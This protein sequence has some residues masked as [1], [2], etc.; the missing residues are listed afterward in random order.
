M[1]QR[2]ADMAR[3]ER[4]ISM[5]SRT[6]RRLAAAAGVAALTVGLVGAGAG[7]AGAAA[8]STMWQDGSSKFTR[9]VSDTTPNE[10]DVVTVSTKFERT[11]IPGEYIYTVKDVHPTCLTY[12]D[13][14]AKVNGS[15]RALES[16]GADFARVK[17]TV[18]EW[19]VG[20]LIGGKPHTFEFSYRVGADCARGVALPTTMHYTSSLGSGTYSDKGPA[21]TVG[22][23]VSST[24]LAAVPA[25]QVG[26]PVT[27]SATVTGGKQDDPVDF[28]DGSTKIGTGRL[29]ASGAATSSWTPTTAGT[30]SVQ[31]R[32]AATAFAN[33]SDS[34]VQSV[35]VAEA[36]VVTS[37]TLQ[38]PQS[39]LT[40]TPVTLSATVDPS[41]ASGTVQFRDGNTNLGAP[42]AVSNGV[43]MFPHTFT[44]AG[45]HSISAVFTGPGFVSSTAPAQTVTVS[46][47]DLATVTTVDASV[48]AQTGAPVMLSASVTPAPNGGTVQ[49]KDGVAAIGGAVEVVNGTAT[50]EH[51]F[52]SVGSHSIT[53]TYSGAAGFEPSTSSVRSV[54]VT[55]PVVT[56]RSTVTLL[57]VPGEAKTGATTDL[58]VTV[59]DFSGAAVDGGTVQF[60]D[61]G[62]DIGDPVAVSS[63]VARLPHTFTVAGTH[64]V[65]AVFSGVPALD[66]SVAATRNV[67]VTVAAP[68]DVE[69]ATALTVPALATSGTEVTLWVSV[70]SSG[71][72]R[73][74][75]QFFD[76][77]T[78][79][80]EAVELVDGAATLQHSFVTPGAHPITAVYSGAE[81]L[82]GS[83]SEA[84]TVQVASVDSTPGGG[85]GTGS[86][87]GLPFGS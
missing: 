73:G 9:T 44:T 36:D 22:K 20:A 80:G 4:T 3:E 71:P 43:A 47:P 5:T 21:L 76:G 30:R 60:R 35:Q 59:R 58:W 85:T 86:L 51:T 42:V 62:Q 10:G 25:A 68:T 26:K 7:L 57:S 49:F 82:S 81:G 19:P 8:D 65:S 63:G 64:S 38:A 31:A 50:L 17:G 18:T 33:G 83:T 55:D 61:G 72:V 67:N 78:P 15:T 34:A 53:A 11:A 1:R 23:N 75:I 32:F 54:S 41:S 74:T 46:V 77:A 87:S 45:A 13:G 66:G 79:I 14:S 39:A 52:S 16:Q 28:Y 48:T 6:G 56:P 12:V 24:S 37:L 84:R 29:N 27:L 69:T 2:N 70:V 40:G